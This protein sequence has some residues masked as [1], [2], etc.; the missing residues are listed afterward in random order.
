MDPTVAGIKN[1]RSIVAGAALM[2][3]DTISV[4]YGKA[5]DKYRYNDRNRGFTTVAHG[6]CQGMGG[7]GANDHHQ[8]GREGHQVAAGV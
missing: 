8:R 7:A 1:K 5:W 6:A 2:F 3:G 4:S